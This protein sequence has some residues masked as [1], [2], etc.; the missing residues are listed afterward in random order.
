[1]AVIFVLSVY[2]SFAAHS[3]HLYKM[4]FCTCQHGQTVKKVVL[5]EAFFKGYIHV[6]YKTHVKI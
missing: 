6:Y 4:I 1:M 5:N 2:Y 3:W